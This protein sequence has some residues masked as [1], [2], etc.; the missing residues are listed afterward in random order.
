[1]A[2][3]NILGDGEKLIASLQQ[4][5][6][7]LPKFWKAIQGI[8]YV[9]RKNAGASGLTIEVAH[10]FAMPNSAIKLRLNEDNICHFAKSEIFYKARS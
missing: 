7:T 6:K 3:K 8:T 10:F 5:M 4:Q 2:Y 1:M 9:K